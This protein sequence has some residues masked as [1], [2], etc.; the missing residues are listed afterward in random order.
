MVVSLGFIF[1]VLL[2]GFILGLLSPVLFM[3]YCVMRAET[4]GH[5]VSTHHEALEG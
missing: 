4:P 1:V 5:V 3:L 2:V